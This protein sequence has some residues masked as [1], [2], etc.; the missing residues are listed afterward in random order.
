MVICDSPLDDLGPAGTAC[1]LPAA[2]LFLARAIYAVFATVFSYSCGL[3]QS[4]EAGVFPPFSRWNPIRDSRWAYQQFQRLSLSSRRLVEYF[5]EVSP[6]GTATESPSVALST[7]LSDEKSIARRR[8]LG[9]SALRSANGWREASPD[10]RSGGVILF[11]ER[12]KRKPFCGLHP[13]VKGGLRME[14]GLKAIGFSGRKRSEIQA[15]APTNLG[16]RDWRRVFS[17]SDCWLMRNRSRGAELAL[18]FCSDLGRPAAGS[19]RRWAA[20]LSGPL[21]SVEIPVPPRKRRNRLWREMAAD[22]GASRRIL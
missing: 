18:S 13:D 7:K 4:W 6:P 10:G 16:R 20:I 1:L 19:T 22:F 14:D 21:Y 17:D 8:C 2:N 3:C 12:G 9:P 5:D 11:R 15:H